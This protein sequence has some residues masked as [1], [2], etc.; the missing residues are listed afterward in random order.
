LS[1]AEKV[2]RPRAL[3]GLRRRLGRRFGAAV[4]VLA[5][6][7]T[8]LIAF[9]AIYAGASM[10]S[11]R[12]V[13]GWAERSDDL[14]Q[15]APPPRGV[16]PLIR[17]DALFYVDLARNGYPQ[18]R[19]EPVFHAAFFPLYPLAV[20][21]VEVAISDTF[22]A[23]IL[24]SN[25]CALLAAFVLYAAARRVGG[26]RS[27]LFAVLLF[28]AAPGAH[29][30]SLPYTEATFALLLALA[31]L[32]VVRSN[33]LLAASA[34]MLATAT[35]SAGVVICAILAVKAWQER[36]AITQALKWSTA[37]MLSAGGLVSYALYCE[38]H[39]SDPLYFTHV[40]SYWGRGLSV[41]GPV[42]ALLAF[43]VDPDS[44]LV[45]L[46]ALALAVALLVRRRVGVELLAGA[47][48]LL[49]LPLMTGTLKSII[50][51]QSVNLPLFVGVGRLL[52]RK[53]MGPVLL[54]SLMMMAYEAFRYG[55]GYA[56]N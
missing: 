16:A 45:V 46:A 9:G 17:W 43:N 42:R 41:L 48:G 25:A 28:L 18:P 23:A 5:F 53:W 34:G 49:L 6:V 24:L 51:F 4:I 13:D 8:R 56:N 50:R 47:W 2:N 52:P 33:P 26:A 44:Y 1:D 38:S 55:A 20:R 30:L 29:F 40:Q 35:R 12:F 54:G 15:T 27:A 36:R 32:G 39:F 3:V 10:P 31:L 37:A 19:P 21:A 11:P 14:H 22:V 7:V